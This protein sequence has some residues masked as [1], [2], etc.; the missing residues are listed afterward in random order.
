[1]RILWLATNLS[2]VFYPL[3]ERT[4]NRGRARQVVGGHTTR[5]SAVG[6]TS[7]WYNRARTEG[8][9]FAVGGARP[10]G[11]LGVAAVGGEL[12]TRYSPAAGHGSSRPG[13][14]RGGWGRCTIVKNGF[15]W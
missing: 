10:D 2:S 9:G 12:F 1:M 6:R 13:L 8:T 15:V 7:G 11:A 3:Q 4:Q 5:T 14:R